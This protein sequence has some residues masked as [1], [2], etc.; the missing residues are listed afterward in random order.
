[1]DVRTDRLLGPEALLNA[2][3]LLTIWIND[4]FI[5]ANRSKFPVERTNFKTFDRAKV[6][7]RAD[8]RAVGDFGLCSMVL[9]APLCPIIA[10]INCAAY[11]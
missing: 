6:T 10:R 7:K 9:C 1:M 3:I 8:P 2:K 4:N 5:N 11:Q